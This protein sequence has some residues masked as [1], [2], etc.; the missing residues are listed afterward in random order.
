MI[1]RP[2][3]AERLLTS[4]VDSRNH[5]CI[6]VGLPI[7]SKFLLSLLSRVGCAIVI[8]FLQDAFLVS[9]DPFG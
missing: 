5:F 9:S 1:G 7:P 6:G 4:D 3:Y 2:L 8:A